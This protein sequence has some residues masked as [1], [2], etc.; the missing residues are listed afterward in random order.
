MKYFSLA[1]IATSMFLAGCEDPAANKPRATINN[2]ANSSSNAATNANAAANTS[3]TAVKGDALPITPETSKVE[4]TGSKVTGKHDG[5]FKQFT[6]MI[7]LVNGKAEESSVSVDIDMAS[8]F[9]DADGLTEHLKNEDFFEVSK[10]PRSTFKSTKIAADST[11]G[12]DSYIVTG[13]LTL[14]GV[15]NSI[16]FPATIKVSDTE[17]SVNSEFSVNRKDFGVN[18]AGMANDLIRDDVVI[19]LDLKSPRK[20]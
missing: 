10:F 18:Y 3:T 19:K 4:F 20:K 16:S 13:D 1:I 11:K 12:A 7:D 17:V 14:R 6:G 15:T 9:T 8:V 5:G 2:S